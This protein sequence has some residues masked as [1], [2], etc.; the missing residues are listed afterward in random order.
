M[1]RNGFIDYIHRT[2]ISTSLNMYFVICEDQ[3]Y[4]DDHCVY[5]LE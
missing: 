5:I 2:G 4:S 3:I 1:F